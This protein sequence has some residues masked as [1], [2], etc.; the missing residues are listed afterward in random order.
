[1]KSYDY[2]QQIT[3]DIYWKFYYYSHIKIIYYLPGTYLHA[4]VYMPAK[5]STNSF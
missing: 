1:M 5:C 4:Y 2:S 3:T